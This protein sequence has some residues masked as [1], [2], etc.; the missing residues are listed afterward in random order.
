MP[1]LTIQE[2]EMIA[3]RIV[4][5]YCRYRTQYGQ[6]VTR[7][8]PKV[9]TRDVLGLQIAYHRLSRSGHVLGLTCMAPI[10]VRVFDD[11]NRPWYVPL[12]GKTVFIDESLKQEGANVGRHNFTLMHEACHLVYGMLFPETYLGVQQRRVYYSLRST[13]RTGTSDWEEWR[14]N[15]LTSAILMPRNL[16][17]QYMQE[18]ELG[19][20]M[21]MV[22]RLFASK[23][24][25]A[26]SHIANK[27]GVSKMALAIRMKQLGL[28]ERNDLDDPYSLVD[29]C[30][31]E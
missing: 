31:D 2:I 14:T 7:I 3:E 15:M 25:D 30:C 13:S 17:L 20:K 8:E 24:Y 27:M 22:N 29:I 26:F 10:E 19:Q 18:Y 12:D 11:L 5:E 21:F 1:Y 28:L 16:I 9:V 6:T 4:H 23:Q